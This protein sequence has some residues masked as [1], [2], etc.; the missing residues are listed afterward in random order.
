MRLNGICLY[1]NHYC[2]FIS[3]IIIV[4]HID[5]IVII[6]QM[7]LIYSLYSFRSVSLSCLLF[8]LL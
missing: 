2:Y 3:E 8:C 1:D 5:A 4:I 6:V 7:I